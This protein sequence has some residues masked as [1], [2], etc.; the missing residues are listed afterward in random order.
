MFVAC[1]I[2]L[3]VAALHSQEDVAPLQGRWLVTA[4]EHNGKP[5][6]SIVGGVMTI[7]RNG[8]EIRTAS[9]N[10]LKGMLRLDTSRRPLH[11][12]MVH[13]DGVE[14]E[15]IYEVTGDRLRLNYVEKGG[16]DPR[17]TTFTT[18]ATTEESIVVLRREAK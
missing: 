15:A 3:F 7:T 4:G 14:W 11:M 16:K 18:S 8:F 13:A 1:V 12:D 9:G 10:V 17:P 6:N 2:T 5:M